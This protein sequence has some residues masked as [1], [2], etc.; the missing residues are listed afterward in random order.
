MKGMYDGMI[1]K[2]LAS[3]LAAVMLLTALASCD[4]EVTDV[5]D[6]TAST[7]SVASELSPEID[8]ELIS[9]IDAYVDDLVLGWEDVYYGKTFTWCGNQG[10]A[11]DH[12]EE[13]GDIRNDALYYRQREIEDLFGI[14]WVNYITQKV[15]DE[16]T[17]SVHDVVLQDVMAG[18]GAFDAAYG[19][20]IFVVQPLFIA[21]TL[22]DMS[23]YEALD[24][25]QKWWQK[26]TVES[27]TIDG[28]LYF[29]NGPIVTTHYEDA[30]CFAFN[31][32]L[33]ENY[34]IENL[35]DLV[36]NN[37]WTYDKMLEIAA[38]VPSNANGAA[39]YRFGDV[40]GLAVMYSYGVT[41]TSYDEMGVPYIAD[42]VSAELVEL[43]DKFSTIFADDT[44][45]ANI[46]SRLKGSPERIEDKY[47][48]EN[49]REMFE[50]NEFLFFNLTTGDAAELR[51]YDVVFGILPMPK[52]DETQEDFISAT[53]AWS[54]VN[55]F[56]PKTAKDKELTGLMIETLAALGRKHIKP[57]YYDKILKSR[58]TYD[59]ESQDMIDI[60]FE[61]KIY[62]MI[63]FLA[64]G[65][66]INQES[67]FVKTVRAAMQEN[68]ASLASKYRMQ[69]KI[70]NRNID[71]MLKNIERDA[72]K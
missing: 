20:T 43:A 12:E 32:E 66:N 54:S 55:V 2:I 27:A 14:N 60:I 49:F 9:E 25:E 21:N 72:K 18:N 42:T 70:V 44:I 51:R 37:K 26:E 11:P 40:N 34:A 56:V 38:Q 53:D 1:K 69:A 13:T 65:G 41:L 3:V 58:A 48:Y 57:A 8:V 62:D 64:V 5:K 35:Y 31:K 52:G 71:N 33:V 17:Y 45:S 59:Y 6:K 36:D 39:S 61:T 67:D 29:L 50:A 7:G 4:A 28:G 15:G 23:G 10:Q 30:Y 63:D 47:G 22:A 68:D 16:P 46:K 24:F 19:T